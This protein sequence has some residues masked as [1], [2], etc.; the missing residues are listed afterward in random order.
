MY[1][2]VHAPT[3]AEARSNLHFGVEP[4]LYLRPS[5][6]AAKEISS[7]FHPCEASCALVRMK[8]FLFRRCIIKRANQETALWTWLSVQMERTML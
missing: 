3:G 4:C 6:P 1:V 7:V 2:Y 5:F 8:F